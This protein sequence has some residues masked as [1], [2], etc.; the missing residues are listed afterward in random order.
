MKPT[1]EIVFDKK[2][3]AKLKAVAKHAGALAEELKNSRIARNVQDVGI[4]WRLFAENKLLSVYAQ[5]NSCGVLGSDI[6]MAEYKTKE[7]KR[8]FYDSGEWKQLVI[9]MNVKNVNGKVEY[10]LIPMSSVR[11]LSVFQQ[12][13]SFTSR[14]KKHS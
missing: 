9:T 6:G 5:C 11:V 14:R 10:P 3:I 12:T 1:I 2:S 13:C 4:P 7:Q 8:K